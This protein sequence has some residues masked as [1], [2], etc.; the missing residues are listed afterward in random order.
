M[1]WDKNNLIVIVDFINQELKNGKPMVR[2]EKEMF[3]ENERVIHKRLI[4]L[5]YKKENNQYIFN[6][7]IDRNITKNISCNSKQEEIN[8]DKRLSNGEEKI[9]KEID[10]EK[11][12][13]LIDNLDNLLKLVN[14]ENDIN[15][16]NITNIRSGVMDVKSFRIDTGIY[17]EVK[18]IA[19]ERAENIGEIINKALIKY[20]LE[21]KNRISN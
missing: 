18:R 11:L 6:G 20:I 17:K 21:E 7:D 3:G 5:G 12:Q 8:N 9:I 1:K 19:H 13:V 16:N 10:K 2:I 14:L 15:T 4:R